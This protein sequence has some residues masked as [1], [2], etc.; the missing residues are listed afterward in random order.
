LLCI[1]DEEQTASPYCVNATVVVLQSTLGFIMT[2]V[3][4][5]SPVVRSVSQLVGAI[6]GG[7]LVYALLGTSVLVTTSYL[8]AA[9][10]FIAWALA[11]ALGCAAG[12]ALGGYLS[13]KA[14][15]TAGAGI[16]DG[17]NA[18]RGWF[19]RVTTTAA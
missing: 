6:G 3:S 10:F 5:S 17:I 13:D 4:T 9:L 14:F 15:G 19:S 18:V 12:A 1:Q 8:A 11:I 2:T 16:G 7:A